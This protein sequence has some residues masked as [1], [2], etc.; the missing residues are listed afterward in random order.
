ME[1]RKFTTSDV[2][3]TLK[4]SDRTV[5]RYIDKEISKIEGK[6]ILS[7]DAYNFIVNKY[8]SDNHRTT[9]GQ[10]SDID[11][12][13]KNDEFDI[14]E[15]F[16]QEEYLEFQKRLTEYPLLKEKIKESKNRLDDSKEYIQTLLNELEYH[17]Q[18]YQKHLEMHQKMIDV[19]QQRNFIEAK[20]KG[21]DQ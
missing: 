8:S 19:F 7:E 17:K 5:R 11:L 4:V 18:T 6:Y 12:S 13:T 21:L 3:K 10:P 15:A 20:E 9:H 16:S 14:I 2:S 1:D